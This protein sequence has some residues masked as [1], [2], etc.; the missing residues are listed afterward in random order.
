[1]RDV[2]DIF[3]ASD[4]VAARSAE[5][6]LLDDLPGRWEG[7]RCSRAAQRRTRFQQRR[8]LPDQIQHFEKAR[9]QHDIGLRGPE[10]R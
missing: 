5:L 7:G 8:R 6:G 1:M 2:D 3:P 9:C 10:R 4:S